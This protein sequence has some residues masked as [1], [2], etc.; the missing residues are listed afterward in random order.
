MQG[1][2]V[3]RDAWGPHSLHTA[4]AT[5][6]ICHPNQHIVT[7]ELPHPG[8]RHWRLGAN[9]CRRNPRIWTVAWLVSY[10]EQLLHDV[11]ELRQAGRTVEQAQEPANAPCNTTGWPSPCTSCQVG[12]PFTST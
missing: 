8:G 4:E 9:G 3:Q 11:S 5:G 2:V 10:L 7:A 12:S 6:C 1:V